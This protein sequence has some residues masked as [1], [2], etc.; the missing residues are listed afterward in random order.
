MVLDNDGLTLCV[1]WWNSLTMTFQ[2]N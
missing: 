1:V 2:S